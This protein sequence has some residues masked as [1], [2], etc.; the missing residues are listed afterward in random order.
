MRNLEKIAIILL[1]I[2]IPYSIMIITITHTTSIKSYLVTRNLKVEVV[3]VALENHEKG[4]INI[5]YNISN[6]LDFKIYII[7]IQS[8]IYS[9]GAYIWTNTTTYIKPSSIYA[10]HTIMKIKFKIPK[11]RI[12]YMENEVSIITYILIQVKQPTNYK[13]LLKFHFPKIKLFLI[14]IDTILITC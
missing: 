5:T 3:E 6:P 2:I 9:K 13:I 8:I 4:I 10:N 1:A 12:N 11:T 7:S 14:S